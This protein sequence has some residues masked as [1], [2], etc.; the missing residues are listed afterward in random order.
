MLCLISVKTAGDNSNKRQ[1][2]PGCSTRALKNLAPVQNS[3][4]PAAHKISS[5]L[6]FFLVCTPRSC[7][8]SILQTFRD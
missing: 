1:D 2:S 4:F 5:D 7:P 6:L 8:R 3:S